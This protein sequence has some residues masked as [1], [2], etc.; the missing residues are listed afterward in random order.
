VNTVSKRSVSVEKARVS[1]EEVVKRSFWQAPSTKRSNR[2][3]KKDCVF[4]VYT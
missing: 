3:D 1:S 2:M 4:N